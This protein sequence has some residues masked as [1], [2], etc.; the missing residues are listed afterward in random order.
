MPTLNLYEQVAALSHD[1][2]KVL[3]INGIVI[4]VNE[5]GLRALQASSSDVMIGKDWVSMWP[6]QSRAK[7]RLCL[8][9]AMAGQVERLTDMCPTFDGEDRW[10]FV[11]IGPLLDDEGAIS[12]VLVVSRDVTD[13][14]HMEEALETINLRLRERLDQANVQVGKESKR[15]RQVVG[16]FHRAQRNPGRLRAGSGDLNERLSMAE[17]AQHLAEEIARQSQASA[18]IGQLAAGVAHDLNNMLQMTIMGLS[19]LHEKADLSPERRARLIEMS[20]SA[21]NRASTTAR[22]MMNFAGAHPLNVRPYDL[23]A[24]V[25]GM[26][27]F[28]AHALGPT[29]VLQVHRQANPLTAMVDVHAVEQALVNLLINA[30]DACEGNGVIEIHFGECA[31]PNEGDDADA[32]N[33]FVSVSVT[34][35]GAGMDEATR[36]RLFEPYFTTKAEGHGTGLGLAQVYGLMLQLGGRISVVSDLGKGTTFMLMFCKASDSNQHGVPTPAT[37]VEASSQQ[38]REMVRSK[39]KDGSK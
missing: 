34:D 26:A 2:I 19:T 11:S 4:D 1:C 8:E 16:Q 14:V 35:S 32:G 36:S 15:Y 23:Q 28:V 3:D 38:Q 6:E 29:M 25:A 39:R 18:A 10:W 17:A 20:L 24:L 30:R 21:V 5:G 7:L 27:E 33:D 13:R 31:R 22:R 37:V 9:R 12:H